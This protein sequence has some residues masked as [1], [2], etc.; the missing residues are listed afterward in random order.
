MIEQEFN[1]V[2]PTGIEPSLPNQV[3]AQ[4]SKI[5]KTLDLSYL[6]DNTE[7]VEFNLEARGIAVKPKMQMT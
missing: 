3:G 6:R 5:T 7:E 4:R 1:I 2:S